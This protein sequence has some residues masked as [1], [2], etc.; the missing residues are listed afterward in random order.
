MFVALCE[1][2]ESYLGGST[3]YFHLRVPMMSSRYDSGISCKKR[4]LV[5]KLSVWCLRCYQAFLFLATCPSHTIK[6]RSLCSPPAAG[7]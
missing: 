6:T 3:N 5:S 1:Q 4:H 7:E 2:V